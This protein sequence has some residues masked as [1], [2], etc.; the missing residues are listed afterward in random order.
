MDIDRGRLTTLL[1][2]ARTE[3][4]AA[5]TL[6]H[7]VY[8]EL[9]RLAQ[10]YFQRLPPNHTLQ[11][12]ALVNEAFLKLMKAEDLEPRDREHFFAL[13]AGAMRQILT[14]HARRRNAGKRGGDNGNR[15]GK[16]ITLSGL[17]DPAGG[18]DPIDLLALDDALRWLGERDERKARVVELRLFGGLSCA[19]IAGMLGLAPRTIE[20]DWFAARAW[21]QR[22]LSDEHA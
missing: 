11:P 1:T 3:Q 22:E 13:L 20:A 21:L 5:A 18:V 19:Q 8:E 10:S 2:R 17:G 6:L 15:D 4:D 12:T 7:E 16:R 9:R 14:D